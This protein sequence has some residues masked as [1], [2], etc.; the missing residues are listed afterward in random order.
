MIRSIVW[1]SKP[2]RRIAEAV[3]RAGWQLAATR[4]QRPLMRRVSARVAFWH[5]LV[6]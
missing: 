3:C 5:E 1:I 4:G 6:D 2:E